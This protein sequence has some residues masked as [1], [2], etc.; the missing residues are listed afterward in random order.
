M[1]RQGSSRQPSFREDAAESINRL[2]CQRL[3]ATRILRAMSQ[4]RLAAAMG[5]SY[6]QL[7][8]YES[9]RGRLSS[10]LL[11]LAALALE[12]PIGYF[13]DMPVDDQ[14]NPPPVTLDATALRAGRDV[15][16]IAD[17]DIRQSLVGLIG[18]LS[19]PRRGGRR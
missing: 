8:R 9:G 15:Q 3:K 5:I 14:V 17:A 18:E 10:A 1:T 7:Q 4:E 19:R 6:Q 2:V 12:A 11:Y 13:F 16:A